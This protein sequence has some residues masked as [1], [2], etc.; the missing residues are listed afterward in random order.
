MWMNYSTQHFWEDVM[1]H[2]KDKCIVFLDFQKTL[3]RIIT[4]LSLE[5]QSIAA[6]ATLSN[7]S[8][9]RWKIKWPQWNLA[10]QISYLG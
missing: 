10:V 6:E 2:S 7:Y 5:A 3:F 8:S 9:Q 1:L 4:G